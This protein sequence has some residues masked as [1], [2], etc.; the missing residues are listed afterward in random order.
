MTQA[1]TIHRRNARKRA[2]IRKDRPG[3]PFVTADWLVRDSIAGV[4]HDLRMMEM[5]NREYP[6]R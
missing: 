1:R 3:I 6:R 2:K 5:I 4:K